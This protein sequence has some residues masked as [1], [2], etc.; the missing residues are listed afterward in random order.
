MCL[1]NLHSDAMRPSYSQGRA[2]HR[3]DASSFLLQ[4]ILYV[5]YCTC[6]DLQRFMDLL[7]IP[8]CSQSC[9]PQG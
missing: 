1:E 8:C 6:Y 9:W 2:S 7:C 3:A 5:A 4:T